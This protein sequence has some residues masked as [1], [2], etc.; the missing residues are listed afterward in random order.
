MSMADAWLDVME[1]RLDDLEKMVFD[2]ED[3]EICYPKVI[4]TLASQNSQLN[5]A[6]AGHKKTEAVISRLPELTQLLDPVYTD[7]L[8]LSQA[9]KAEVVL[10]E[11]ELIRQ[12]A[13]NLEKVEQMLNLLNS[14]H[15][16]CLESSW[17]T[18]GFDEIVPSLQGKLQELGKVHIKQQDD[19]S[20]LTEQTKSLLL[21]YNNCINLLSKQFIAWDAKLT[22]IEISKQTESSA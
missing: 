6:L 21:Y 13:A 11:E 22:Q 3:K 12:Q 20:E 9:A 8:T 2:T 17:L 10:A 19:A 15:I 5:C 4:S 1:Q 16:K 7:R 14:E 18:C